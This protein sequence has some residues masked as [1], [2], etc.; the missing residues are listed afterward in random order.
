MLV[1][2]N[3]EAIFWSDLLYFVD[4]YAKKYTHAVIIFRKCDMRVALMQIV[5]LQSS[6]FS[7]AH[8]LL[9]FHHATA[10]YRRGT[11]CTVVIS[12]GRKIN[13]CP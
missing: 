4:S 1:R 9:G 10:T 5:Q 6:K 12:Q 8:H 3:L 7:S 2:Q 13:V 11:H